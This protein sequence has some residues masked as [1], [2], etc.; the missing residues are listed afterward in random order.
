MIALRVPPRA[1]G[2][3][4]WG[5]GAATPKIAGSLPESIQRKP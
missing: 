2:A 5:D 1:Q 4:P 3:T